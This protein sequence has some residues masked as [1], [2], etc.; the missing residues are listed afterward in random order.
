MYLLYSLSVSTKAWRI[1]ERETIPFTTSCSSTTT[2]L[3]TCREHKNIVGVTLISARYHFYLRNVGRNWCKTN[4]TQTAAL[5][6]EVTVC[7]CFFLIWFQI[8]FWSNHDKS[9]WQEHTNTTHTNV[10]T[11]TTQKGPGMDSNAGCS[12]CEANGGVLL[13][14][15]VLNFLMYT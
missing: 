15:M 9:I 2:S 11:N 5:M 14:I 12:C 1:S 13:F 6:A 7:C 4:C 10:H 8:V 3:C